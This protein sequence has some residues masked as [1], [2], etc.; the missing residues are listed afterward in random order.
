V[1]H[2]QRIVRTTAN[3][4][5]QLI[6]ASLKQPAER[7]HGLRE[8]PFPRSADRGLI[9]APPVNKQPEPRRFDFRDQLI[10]ASL[11]LATAEPP[12]TKAPAC[13]LP[14]VT[15]AYL[16]PLVDT[17]TFRPCNATLLAA[18]FTQTWMLA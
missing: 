6:A 10:A 14:T 13:C 4:R 1:E 8:G 18:K 5:D 16:W 17:P 12:F 11:K 3:F 2:R 15:E 9:E 7:E